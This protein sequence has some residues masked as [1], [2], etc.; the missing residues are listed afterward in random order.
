MSKDRIELNSPL[1]IPPTQ[2]ARLL[3]FMLIGALLFV[4]AT[5]FLPINPYFRFQQ[6]DGTILFRARWIYERIHFDQTPID[7]AV[8]GSSRLEA[9]VRAAELSDLLSTKLNRPIHLVNFALPQEGRNLHWTL[10][11]ELLENRPEVRLILLSVVEETWTSH[12]GFRFL[13]D[14]ASIV[15]SPIIY[16]PWYA[17]DLLTIPYSHI[18]YF[19]QGLAPAIF[20]LSPT[21]DSAIYRERGFDPSNTFIGAHGNL[22]DRE[23]LL[24]SDDISKQMEEVEHRDPKM[25]LFPFDQRY[26]IERSFTRRIAALAQEKKVKICFLRIPVFGQKGQIYDKGFYLSFGPV[27]EA[28]QFGADPGDYMDIGHLGRRGSAKLTPWLAEQL[29]PILRTAEPGQH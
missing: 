24:T 9:S 14:D 26:A 22:V 3:G 12:P 16:N 23:S 28:L 21:F 2:A 1:A 10:A 29:E 5:V 27:F 13:A 19:V 15:T 18:A 11:K 17:L 8:I 7:V 4:A 6:G 20:K 25:L